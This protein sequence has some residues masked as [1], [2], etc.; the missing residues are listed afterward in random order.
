MLP[1]ESFSVQQFRGIRNIELNQ[2]GRVNILVG[3]NNCGKTSILEALATYARPLRPSEWFDVV[4]RREISNSRSVLIEGLSWL[5]PHDEIIS[6]SPM[7]SGRET[8]VSGKGTCPIR[9][10]VARL[11]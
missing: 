7:P 6:T 4:R 1:L 5:F 2:L 8:R 9:E 3:R 10:V 11:T